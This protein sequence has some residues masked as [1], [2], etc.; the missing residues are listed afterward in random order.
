[1]QMAHRKNADMV[2]SML[3][4]QR[5]PGKRGGRGEGAFIPHPHIAA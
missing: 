5:L 1:M 4:Q 2:W 3:E